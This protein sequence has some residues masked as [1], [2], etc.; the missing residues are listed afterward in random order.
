MKTDI[1]IKNSSS[2]LLL[3]LWYNNTLENRYIYDLNV[4]F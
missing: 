1:K 3:R 2:T 4:N